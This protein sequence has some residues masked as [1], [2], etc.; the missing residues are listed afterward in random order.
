MSYDK[1]I[2]SLESWVQDKFGI[3]LDEDYRDILI[4]TW[5]K[6]EDN[7]PIQV[8]QNPIIG[9]RELQLLIERY[10][11]PDNSGRK[12]SV[13]QTFG[14][15]SCKM[16]DGNYKLAEDIQVPVEYRGDAFGKHIKWPDFSKWGS[17]IDYHPVYS[18][19]NCAH[20]VRGLANQIS[21]ILLPLTGQSTAHNL[22]SL[23]THKEQLRAEKKVKEFFFG[24]LTEDQA[25]VV[26]KHVYQSSSTLSWL[27][28]GGDEQ[29]QTRRLRAAHSYPLLLPYFDGHHKMAQEQKQDIRHGIDTGSPL[30]PLLARRLFPEPV[31]KALIRCLGKIDGDFSD[32]NFTK[33]T[34]YSAVLNAL[35][36][37][38]YPVTVNSM[39]AC[40][41]VIDKAQAISHILGNSAHDILLKAYAD[42]EEWD[43]ATS[44]LSKV[45]DTA[46]WVQQIK[47]SVI[48]PVLWTKTLTDKA[49]NSNIDLAGSFSDAVYQTKLDIDEI[50]VINEEQA[51]ICIEKLLGHL[52]LQE[53]VKCSDDWHQNLRNFHINMQAVNVS[54]TTDSYNWLPLSEPLQAPN[55]LWLTP[56]TSVK[57]LRQE[58]EFLEHCVGEVDTY[59]KQ[60]MAGCDHIISLSRDKDGK[61]RLTTG[62]LQEQKSKSGEVRDLKI[63]QHQGFQRRDPTGEEKEA[64][65]WY[66]STL[67]NDP[68]NAPDWQKL[69]EPRAQARDKM[70][71]ESVSE[72]ILEECGLD[73]LD[74]NACR[75]A[76]NLMRPY[77][78][79]Q[80][81]KLGYD[82]FRKKVLKILT[83][84]NRDC[85]FSRD[86]SGAPPPEVVL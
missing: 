83:K 43:K 29:L 3:P 35:P 11:P 81:S 75:V 65:E 48:L 72:D 41:S 22:I 12:G 61:N 63:V 34:E 47:K 20:R 37:E 42:W 53:I 23:L 64:L 54:D 68:E 19:D 74:E 6:W 79:E 24:E 69:E 25:K 9:S 82:I 38:A 70:D 39:K 27:Q 52:P 10:T 85:T 32:I 18:H 40:L 56:L 2:D 50:R 71:S 86:D 14:A 76:Y 16:E 45:K 78:P 67:L 26:S 30:T 51:R 28:A 7:F 55:G 84:A 66:V 31:S 80:I 5:K 59:Y 46:D 33:L 13:S 60:C 8:G 21:S 58:S 36:A 4:R 1:Y 57:D 49:S 77:L 15:R 62:Q 73:P 44:S 17:I